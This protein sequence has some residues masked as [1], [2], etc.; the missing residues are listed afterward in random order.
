M[1][2]PYTCRAVDSPG[3]A[4]IQAYCAALP[5]PPFSYLS[6]LSPAQRSAIAQ[7]QI[8][9]ALADDTQTVLVVGA[10]EQLVG[11]ASVGALAWDSEIFEQAMG[12]VR[13]WGLA[14]DGGTDAG[15]VLMES[16]VQVCKEKGFASVDMQVDAQDLV[17]FH[18]ASA[19]GFKLMASHVVMV[20]DLSEGK[21]FEVPDH[22]VIQ[23]AVPEDAAAVGAAAAASYAP[24]SR[25]VVDPQLG[26]GVPGVFRAWAE[27]CVRGRSERVQMARIDGELAGYCA[28]S[29][30]KAVEPL[31]VVDLELTA[32]LQAYRNRG[33]LGAMVGDA[34]GVLREQGYGYAQVWTHMLNGGMQRGC[35]GHG[36]STAGGRHTLH[37]HS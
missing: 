36:A 23:D 31:K 10:G 14:G 26:A 4:E 35:G 34:L 1:S 25:F 27:N 2:G 3:D 15:A 29:K 37:W 30:V 8:E 22:V 32:V 21:A 6:A 5:Y 28:W 33:V 9:E 12:R 7:T 24:Y 17:T 19:A 16:V 20:W 18:L 11:V 13:W